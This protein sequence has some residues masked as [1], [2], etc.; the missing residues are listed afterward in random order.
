MIKSYIKELPL[1]VP[2]R[3]CVESVYKK[4]ADDSVFRLECRIL[5][6]VHVGELIN[7]WFYRKRRDGQLNKITCR[8][9]E[10]LGGKPHDQVKCWELNGKIFEA[11]S[12]RPTGSNYP[13]YGHFKLLGIID[14][15]NEKDEKC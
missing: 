6:G 12:W 8:L 4:E 3:M 10:V 2:V 9:L 5:D 7:I 11:N 15:P 14:D 13:M 1:N